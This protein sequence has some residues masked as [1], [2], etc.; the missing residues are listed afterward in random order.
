MSTLKTLTQSDNVSILFGEW[1]DKLN[2]NTYYDAD[3]QVNEERHL[4]P[5]QYGYSA[6]DRQSIDEAL[7]RVGYK[8]EV[9]EGDV[10]APYRA[11]HIN[12]GVK[13]KRELFK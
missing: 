12:S 5:Y 6:G 11:L 13:L 4:L 1:L 9:N 7:A 10:H 2:G 8:V 3:V